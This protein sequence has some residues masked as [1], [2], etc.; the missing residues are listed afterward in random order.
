MRLWALV[1][2]PI[3]LSFERVFYIRV[4]RNP[5]WFRS[6]CNARLIAQ[7]RDPV[8]AV[9]SAFY[10]FKGVQLAVFCGW[11]YAFGAGERGYISAQA[12]AVALA[13]ILILTGQILNFGVFLRLG[14]V[15]VFYGDIFGHELPRCQQFPFSVLNHPQYVGAL[16]SVW[17]FFLLTRYPNLDWLYLPLVETAYYAL[18]AYFEQ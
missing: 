18:G 1:A 2:A 11:C 13:G 17:G 8:T 16:L 5:D 6:F 3:L 12:P 9:R 10:V 14:R 15:G 7:L 4:W